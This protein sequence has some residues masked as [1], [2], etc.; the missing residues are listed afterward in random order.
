[1]IKY[2]CQA[3]LFSSIF[4]AFAVAGKVYKGPGWHYADAWMGDIGIV[5]CL[6][7]GLA[8][9]IPKRRPVTK[10]AVIA[11]VATAVEVF[12]W[13]GIPRS[14][15]L[16]RPFVFVLGSRFDPTDFLCYI[17]GL[18]AAWQVDRLLMTK[19]EKEVYEA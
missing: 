19:S 17:V 18:F 14:W 6:Y 2:R 13:T 10:T 15:N 4:L 12:Q 9:F 3:I 8:V 7:F 16:P 1:M 11:A 5:G